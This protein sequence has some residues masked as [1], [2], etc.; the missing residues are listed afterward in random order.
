MLNPS[1]KLGVPRKEL[2]SAKDELPVKKEPG[3]IRKKAKKVSK[4]EKN[5]LRTIKLAK[6]RTKF[7]IPK[8]HF[9][10]MVRQTGQEFSEQIRWKRTAVD[11]LQ[12]HAEEYLTELFNKSQ[13]L[14]MHRG[15]NDTD[16]ARKTLLPKDM[17]M[18]RWL[19]Y[20]EDSRGPKEVTYKKKRATLAGR[21]PGATTGEGTASL[22]EAALAGALE[23]DNGNA[24]GDDEDDDF[25][26]ANV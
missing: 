25:A 17:D 8:A 6:E 11:E 20:G 9:M 10:R 4:Q 22:D 18:V 5:I 16:A 1:K 13:A 15:S 3:V 19:Y 2:E 7:N 26:Q 12:E 14:A 21:Q 23:P 24:S